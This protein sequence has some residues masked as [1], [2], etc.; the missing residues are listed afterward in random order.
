MKAWRQ[1]RRRVTMISVSKHVTAYS[2]YSH[3]PCKRDSARDAYCSTYY[4]IRIDICSMP[5]LIW[6]GAVL[7]ASH[8]Q[9]PCFSTAASAA[10]ASIAYQSLVTHPLRRSLLSCATQVRCHLCNALSPSKSGRFNSRDKRTGCPPILP[11]Q[12][13]VRIL[14]PRLLTHTNARNRDTRV[15]I[16][17]AADG[18]IVPVR[19]FVCW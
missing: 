4:Q 19:R 6:L 7:R 9:V 12:A 17:Q 8:P 3:R 15:S 5:L 11:R 1:A 14:L 2:S 16:L 13:P 10:S 18:A